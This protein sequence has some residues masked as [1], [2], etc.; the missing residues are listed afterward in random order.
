MRDCALQDSWVRTSSTTQR[1]RRRQKCHI[2]SLPNEQRI[3]GIP[4]AD[5]GFWN[6]GVVGSRPEDLRVDF[7]MFVGLYGKE[8]RG[9]PRI[10]K[11]KTLATIGMSFFC[12]LLQPDFKFTSDKVLNASLYASNKDFTLALSDTSDS[13]SCNSSMN[14]SGLYS[15]DTNL[16]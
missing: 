5:S 7:Y 16:S 6:V 4:T 8:V 9:V 15:V 11:N 13:S 10:V 3:L 12:Q 2:G 1:K 14:S